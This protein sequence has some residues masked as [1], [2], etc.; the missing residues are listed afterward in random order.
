M[1]FTLSILALVVSSTIYGQEKPVRIV[2]DITSKD[3]ATHA[4]VVRHV[5]GMAKAYPQSSF[6]V[7][8]YGGALPMVLSDK[9]TVR[10][11]VAQL[12]TNKNISFKVCAVTMNRNR[13]TEANLIPGVGIV[14]DG[15]LEIVTRQGEGWGY[16][17]EA[18]N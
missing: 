10:S 16:I 1:K 12:V 4:A 17:K 11:K 3:T 14:P 15:I 7:V 13:V 5:T 6:E 8:I 9:S 18:H 2:F